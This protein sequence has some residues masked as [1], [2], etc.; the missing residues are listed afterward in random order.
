MSN[1]KRLNLVN[2]MAE[3]DKR[4][5]ALNAIADIPKTIDEFENLLCVDVAIPV[6]EFL[7]ESA[8]RADISP[9]YIRETY[10]AFKA[11]YEVALQLRL[12]SK[13]TVGIH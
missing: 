1:K 2:E 4:D 3:M 13:K 12:L 10:T 5:A 8:L 6:Q 7:T 11:R 9:P